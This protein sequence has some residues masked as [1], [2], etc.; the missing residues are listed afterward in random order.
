MVAL[1]NLIKIGLTNRK[2]KSK[3][4]DAGIEGEDEE[5]DGDAEEE[6]KRLRLRTS[7]FLAVKCMSELLVTH[8][9]FNYR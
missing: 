2:V 6:E 9:H 1:E 5:D 3:Q 7:A 8:P 4:T